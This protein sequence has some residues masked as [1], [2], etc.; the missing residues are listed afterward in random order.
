M[1][2]P[3]L[4][5]AIRELAY[6]VGLHVRYGEGG[7]PQGPHVLVRPRCP[8]CGSTET[9]K[10][11]TRRNPVHALLDRGRVTSALLECRECHCQTEWRVEYATAEKAE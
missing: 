3:E 8:K 4:A 9:H 10:P 6:Q 5:R 1:T 11:V 7:L 2:D